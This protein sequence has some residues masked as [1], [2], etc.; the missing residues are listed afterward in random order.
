[1]CYFWG[2]NVLTALL[3]YVNV[4]FILRSF[5]LVFALFWNKMTM[6]DRAGV[7]TVFGSWHTVCMSCDIVSLHPVCVIIAPSLSQLSLIVKVTIGPQEKQAEQNKCHLLS[8][9]LSPHP[10]RVIKPFLVVLYIWF[11]TSTSLLRH[12]HH[13]VTSL[14]C[15]FVIM[16]LINNHMVN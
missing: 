4:N 6:R 16:I 8:L 9:T 11:H 1:M 10:A 3:I 14:V 5:I 2:C 12:Q 13:N 7:D 15:Y